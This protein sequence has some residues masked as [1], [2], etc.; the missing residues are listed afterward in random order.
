[1]TY[2]GPY[3]YGS[4]LRAGSPC[5]S[6][7]EAGEYIQRRVSFLLSFRRAEHLR[8]GSHIL[9]DDVIGRRNITRILSKL[10]QPQPP[11]DKKQLLL[12]G[13][14]VRTAGNTSPWDDSTMLT[15][16]ARFDAGITYESLLVLKQGTTSSGR[17]Y[18]SDELQKLEELEE[19]FLEILHAYQI[20]TKR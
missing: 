3:P 4:I 8:R 6:T 10:S 9:R 1:M 7:I 20:T 11:G 5:L 13:P 16:V 12:T 17:V 14:M 2:T 18:N 19:E 15:L